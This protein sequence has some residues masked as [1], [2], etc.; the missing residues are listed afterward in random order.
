[1]ILQIVSDLHIE[2]QNDLLVNPLDLI[3]PSA[4]ILIL[5]GDIGSIYKYD[6]LKHFLEHICKHF[7][8]VLYI[9]GNHEY[10][11]VPDKK[12]LDMDSLLKNLYLLEKNISNLFILNQ[13][14]IK[15]GNICI[16]GCTLWSEPK[17]KIPKYIVRI[18]KLN[19]NLYKNMHNSDLTYIKK[20]IKYCNEKKLELIM[21][22][23]HCPTNKVLNNVNPNKIK[24][25]SSLYTT[26]L[27]YLLTKDLVNT[28]ICGHV[29]A[30]FNFI[31]ENGT[32]VVG[33]QRGKPKDNIKD[34]S[35]QFTINI[36]S[37]E[38]K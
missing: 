9:P 15:I 23:H 31:T 6:Q 3:D 18:Y 34:Y 1:M 16:A 4:D 13:K 22:T 38:N 20:I 33:N 5:A 7:K 2:Y 21:V 8:L 26:D 11:V 19:T 35:K 17:M 32:R 25:F 24:K 27:D 12:Y 36:P 10:Y 37:I 30:N 28:W 29:H 14:S